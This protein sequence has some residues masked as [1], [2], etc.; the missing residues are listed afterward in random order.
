[1]NFQE[2]L[3]AVEQAAQRAAESQDAANVAGQAPSPRPSIHACLKARVASLRRLADE[4]EALD[5]ALPVELP[6]AADQAL[7]RLLHG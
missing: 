5:R 1:M 6:P 7:H 3:Q 2:A 4:L